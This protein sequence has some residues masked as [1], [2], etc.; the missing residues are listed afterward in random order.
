[1]YYLQLLYFPLD[2]SGEKEL[3]TYSQ[4]LSSRNSLG[5]LPPELTSL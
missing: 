5:V 3:P 1:M 4:V 2:C